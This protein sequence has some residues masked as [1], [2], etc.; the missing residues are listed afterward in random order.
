MV[1]RTAL[2]LVVEVTADISLSHHGKSQPLALDQAHVRA[3]FVE[4]CRTFQ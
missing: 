4:R 2:Q 3:V 1:A